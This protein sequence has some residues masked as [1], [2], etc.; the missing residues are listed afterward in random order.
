MQLFTFQRPNAIK[1]LEIS[2]NGLPLQKVL[3]KNHVYLSVV[4]AYDLVWTQ[5]AI[6]NKTSMFFPVALLH[7]AV[8]LVCS[9]LL[10]LLH[11]LLPV[12]PPISLGAVF[13]FWTAEFNAS[14]APLACSTKVTWPYNFVNTWGCCVVI[15]TGDYLCFCRLCRSCFR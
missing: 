6:Q 14:L 3:E 5:H 1:Y 4:G 8:R 2:T 11:N 13:L 12:R 15:Q 10:L 7:H 9:L